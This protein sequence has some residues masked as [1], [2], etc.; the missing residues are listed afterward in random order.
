MHNKGWSET[1][2]KE[3]CAAE[4]EC[5]AWNV[6]EHLAKSFSVVNPNRNIVVIPTHVDGSIML[7]KCKWYVPLTKEELSF[8]G[9]E[10]M[11]AYFQVSVSSTCPQQLK[12]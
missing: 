12:K 9:F 7:S 11:E 3:F 5:A 8:T 1:V 4:A 2:R 10:R 6:V